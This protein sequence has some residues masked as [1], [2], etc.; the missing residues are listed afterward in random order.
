MLAIIVWVLLL[1]LELDFALIS[2]SALTFQKPN[3]AE[4][5]AERSASAS[6]ELLKSMNL[7]ETGEVEC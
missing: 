4:S 6:T 1:N 3:E 2:S 7:S 5:E